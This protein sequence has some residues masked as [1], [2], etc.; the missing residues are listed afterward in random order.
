MTRCRLAEEL[1]A[2]PQ[3]IEAAARFGKTRIDLERRFEFLFRFAALA[4]ID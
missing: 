3:V 2:S 4:G 1:A